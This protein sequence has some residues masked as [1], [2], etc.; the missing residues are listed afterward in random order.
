MKKKILFCLAACLLPLSFASCSGNNSSEHY[1]I[2][3]GTDGIQYELNE[4][5]DGYIVTDSLT[6]ET[7]II[8]PELYNNLPVREIGPAAFR[9]DTLDSITLPR[10]LRKIDDEAFLGL[11]DAGSG[12]LTSIVVPEGVEEIGDKA[13]YYC[14]SLRE[15]KLPK[16]LKKIGEKAFGLNTN[17]SKIS[18]ENNKND[19]FE[20]ASNVLYTVGKTELVCYPQ[21]I[22]ALT[23]DLPDSVEIIRNGAMYGNQ[24][25]TGITISSNSQLVEIGERAMAALFNV[26]SIDISRCQYLTTIGEKAFSENTSLKQMEIPASVTS[27][28]DAVFYKSSS[29][30]FIKLN[31]SFEKLPNETFSSC[32]RLQNVTFTSA[33]TIKTIGKKAFSGTAITKFPTLVNLETIE[34]DAFNACMSLDT[35]TFPNKL[36]SIGVGAFNNCSSVSSIIFPNGLTEITERSFNRCENLQSIDLSNTQ[37]TTIARTAF[38]GCSSVVEIEFPSTLKRIEEKAFSG[39]VKLETLE[40][41]KGL[42]YIGYAAFDNYSALYKVFI[43]STVKEIENGAF[44]G[45][46][47]R[48]DLQ[49]FIESS[50]APE[51]FSSSFA[52]YVPKRDIHY[53]A[54]KQDFAN[55]KHVY[56]TRSITLSDNEV[57][58]S[59]NETKTITATAKTCE[60]DQAPTLSGFEWTSSNE[61]VATVNNEGLITALSSG[62]TTITVKSIDNNST[63]SCIV[64]VK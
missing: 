60:E 4:A 57:T 7:D 10:S 27:M 30:Q 14:P 15:I 1:T 39:L 19:Y 43:P 45:V 18:L 50:T 23:Y 42:E 55:A 24:N 25:L 31:N 59:V 9:Y 34:E 6:I 56:R 53:G 13:F 48:Q 8:I 5:Q 47:G 32:S 44:A 37:V 28:G 38:M 64:T 54:S 21:G 36:K 62:T 29:I 63:V 20:V 40:F 49:I 22:K 12:L 33:S 35:I 3:E 61:A 58:L 46:T 2:T 51:G 41:P 17:L 26:E 16:T 52:F 11:V